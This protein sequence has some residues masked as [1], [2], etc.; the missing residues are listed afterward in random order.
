MIITKRNTNNNSNNNIKNN[1]DNNEFY[2]S[3][4]PGLW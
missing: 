1:D 2:C 4:T 3:K